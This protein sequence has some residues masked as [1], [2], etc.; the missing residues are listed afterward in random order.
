MIYFSG[1]SKIWAFEGF[2]GK[3]R[4]KSLSKEK[5]KGKEKGEKGGK[6][7][8]KG[9]REGKKGIKVNKGTEKGKRKGER[10]G[11]RR[12]DGKVQ[13][14]KISQTLL[15]KKSYSFP[16]EKEYHLSY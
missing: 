1:G 6:G 5:G 16:R 13:K 14:R 8:K 10:E 7:R 2:G 4:I 11:N 9:K 3:I 15:G 12:K